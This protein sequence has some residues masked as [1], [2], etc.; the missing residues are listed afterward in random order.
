MATET[1]DL[2]IIGSGP[3][4]TS[5]A[6]AFRENGG[7]G[8]VVICTADTEQPYYRPPLSK[9]FLQGES[10]ATEIGMH[11]SAWYD[12]N[13]V[14]V[15][16]GCRVERIDVQNETVVTSDGGSIG[17][18]SLVLA[19]GAA[20]VPLPVDGGDSVLL[21][22]S[23]ADAARLRDASVDAKSAVVIGA[24]FIGC[25][26]AASLAARGIATT[27]VAPERLPQLERLGEE[28]GTRL[29][30]IVE[31]AGVRYSGGAEVVAVEPHAVTLSSGVRLAADVVLA[32]TGIGP[33]AELASEAGLAVE[34]GRIV[35][36]ANMRTSVHNVFA[37][38]DV[39]I[40]HNT[41]ANRAVATEHWQDAVDQ[42]TVAG[43]SAAGASAEWDSV[44]G[45]WT[46]IGNET[47]KYAA[48]GDGYD[49]AHLIDHGD[50]FTVWYST[51]GVTVGALTHN[52]DAD[53]EIAESLV[54]ER[55]S[56]PG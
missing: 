4:G 35:V 11:D 8:R 23:L 39:A 19:S 14:E 56:P 7:T 54:R 51:D 1:A 46:T 15:R 32:A 2:L 31:A 30:R 36:D 44:P 18:R 50:G 29:L 38:G 49:T 10:E 6:E 28:A 42:G 13:S 22:R 9:D 34:G 21:L 12:D 5:A 27:I 16:T 40:A 55:R 48:W 52:A 24:G 26:A 25:E 53:Y 45:F 43:S 17:Y 20:P 37:A 3:A 41:T 33:Q 47:V